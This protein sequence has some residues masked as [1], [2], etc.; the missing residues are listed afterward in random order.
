MPPEHLQMNDSPQRLPGVSQAV[1]RGCRAQHE[2]QLHPVGAVS[3][4]CGNESQNDIGLVTPHGQQLHL[5]LQI[6]IGSVGDMDLK[7]RIH[8]TL[9]KLKILHIW[10]SRSGTGV[11]PH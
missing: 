7:G 2:V 5:Q 8:L 10:Y 3:L 1:A 6:L 4:P 11:F 9:F